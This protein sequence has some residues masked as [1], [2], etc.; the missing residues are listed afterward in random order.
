MKQN[1]LLIIVIALLS[2]IIGRL[3][4]NNSQRYFFKDYK[5]GKVMYDTSTG[6]IYYYNNDMYDKNYK[7]V[8]KRNYKEIYK[9][10]PF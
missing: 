9:T 8:N 6:D 1:Y 10:R 3:S 5:D 4:V 7:K 2:F